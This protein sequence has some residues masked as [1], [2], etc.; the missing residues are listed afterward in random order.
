MAIYVPDVKTK[1]WVII[2]E[3]RSVR[4][5]DIKGAS[6]SE[7]LTKECPFCS[8]N[9]HMTPPELYRIGKG[10]RRTRLACPSRS[11]KFPITDIH[12]YSFIVLRMIKIFRY[13]SQIR[14]YEY[15]PHTETDIWHMQQMVM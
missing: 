10:D 9:E 7:V 6:H 12:E 15:S 2:S 14:L 11:N 8:G 13:A 3:T 1:R 5:D 4:P